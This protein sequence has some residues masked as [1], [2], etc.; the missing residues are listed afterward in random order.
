MHLFHRLY[1]STF[2]GASHTDRWISSSFICMYHIVNSFT[3]AK[4]LS[5]LLISSFPG[6]PAQFFFVSKHQDAVLYSSQKRNSSKLKYHRILKEIQKGRRTGNLVIGVETYLKKGF[7]VSEI[8]NILM[9]WKITLQYCI[10]LDQWLIAS[11][12]TFRQQWF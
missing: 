8:R 7:D 5:G 2:Q 10:L 12:P 9:N 11:V 6:L 3:N 4:Y 1:F